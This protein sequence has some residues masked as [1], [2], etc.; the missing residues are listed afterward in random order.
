VSTEGPEIL[1]RR[2]CW[3]LLH[4]ISL[5]RFAFV[6]DGWPV[7]LPVNYAIDGEEIL[8]RTAAGPKLDAARRHAQVALQADSTDSLYRSGWSVLV[9][10]R[11]T[12]ITDTDELRRLR[13]VR[14]EPWARGDRRHWLRIHPIQLTGRR[15]PRSW[16][17]P[18]P[19]H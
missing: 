17:Y 2:D 6:V 15:L 3:R 1:G 5:G 12:E 4:S 10:G 11:A 19:T 13:A 9:L 18:G 14:L 16:R 7:V 8:V